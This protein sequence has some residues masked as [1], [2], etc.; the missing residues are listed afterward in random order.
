M[1]GDRVYTVS[2]ICIGRRE[3]NFFIFIFFEELRS[4]SG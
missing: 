3:G 2:V 1:F 4:V